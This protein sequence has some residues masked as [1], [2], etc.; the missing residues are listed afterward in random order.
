MVWR[1]GFASLQSTL[2]FKKK[3][4]VLGKNLNK[5]ITILF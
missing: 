4:L 1:D 5:F 3:V 2:F